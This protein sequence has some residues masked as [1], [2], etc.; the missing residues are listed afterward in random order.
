MKRIIQKFYIK[1]FRDK[2]KNEITRQRIKLVLW[3]IY[4]YRPLLFTN[5]ISLRKRLTLIRKCIIID[6]NIVHAHK[7]CELTPI[8]IAIL[9]ENNIT[10]NS[11][12]IPIIVEAGCW[13]GGSSSK[14]SLTCALV[15]YKFHIYDS[16]AGVEFGDPSIAEAYFFGTYVG[17]EAIVR[18]NIKKYGNISVCEFHKGWFID[19]FQNFNMPAKIVYIDCDL[20]KGTMEV[21]EAVKPLMIKGGKIYT[22]DYHIPTIKEALNDKS[23]WEKLGLIPPAIDKLKRNIAVIS[24]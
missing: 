19:T 5:V 6:W 22:Q 12:D 3:D 21:I 18:G 14:F 17:D 15:G 13:L 8:M 2:I 1:Y 23:T 11:N 16:F 7:P 24:C 9:N 20:K 10:Q 4:G